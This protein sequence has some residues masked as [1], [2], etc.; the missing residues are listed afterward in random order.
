MDDSD[1]TVCHTCRYENDD[2]QRWINESVL[3]Q[4]KKA[5]EFDQKIILG[6][7]ELNNKIIKCDEKIQ[8]LELEKRKFQNLCDSKIQDLIKLPEVIEKAKQITKTDFK[9]T[10]VEKR[11]GDPAKLIGDATKAKKVLGWNPKFFGLEKILQTAWEWHKCK[12]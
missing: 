1:G 4:E 12:M 6:E 5:A 2:A 10:L 11:V 9:V 7:R 8:D 3:L